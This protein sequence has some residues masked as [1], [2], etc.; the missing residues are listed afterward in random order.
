[1]ACSSSNILLTSFTYR[2]GAGDSPGVPNLEYLGLGYDMI[3]GN[4]RGSESSEVDPGFRYRVLRLRQVQ[5]DLTVDG[6]YTVPLGTAIKVRQTKTIS[7]NQVFAALEKFLPSLR[8]VL[9]YA[10]SIHQ[11]A[12]M[13]VLRE[14]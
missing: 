8:L 5:S 7:H 11:V 1:M 3:R 10:C 12:S 14:K 6:A 2:E 9:S 13:T 4:P